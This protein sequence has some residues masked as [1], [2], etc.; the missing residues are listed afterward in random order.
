MLIAAQF[1]VNGGGVFEAHEIDIVTLAQQ[2]FGDRIDPLLEIAKPL[3]DLGHGN[4]VGPSLLSSIVA[5]RPHCPGYG[6]H[7]SNAR[8]KEQITVP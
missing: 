3:L 4:A 2:P 8:G 7:S 1:R 6:N 5:I